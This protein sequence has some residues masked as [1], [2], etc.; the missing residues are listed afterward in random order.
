MRKKEK[1]E[2]V[3][4]LQAQLDKSDQMWEEGHSPA[5]IVG[6]LQGTIKA[7]IEHIKINN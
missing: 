6:W 7:T 1:Q 3:Q 5:Y 2:L 4:S